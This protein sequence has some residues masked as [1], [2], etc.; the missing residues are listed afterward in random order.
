MRGNAQG[1]HPFGTGP[2]RAPGANA[3]A[4]ARESQIDIMAAKAGMDPVE[5]RL[6]NLTDARMRRVLEAAAKA[7]GWTPK[8]GPSGRGYGVALGTD[9]GTLLRQH[10]RSESGQGD[11][12]RSRSFACWPRRTWAWSSIPKAPRS[13]WKA[14]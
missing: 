13:R 8:P 4:F 7:F 14:A 2:W 1:L 10:G 6:L 11:G 9:A 5:F 3:N 12:H